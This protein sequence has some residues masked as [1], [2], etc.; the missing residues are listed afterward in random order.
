MP[1]WSDQ[2]LIL[3]VRPYAE[4]D[5]VVNVLT[6]SHGRQAG[7]VRGGQSSKHRGTLQP[8][9]KVDV[10]WR[11]RLAE[12]LGAMQIDMVPLMLRLCWMML[13]LRGCLRFAH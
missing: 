11:A 10:F 3:S 7:L 13:S 5:A 9:N 4:H 8:G 2:A 6:T 12:H 1:E